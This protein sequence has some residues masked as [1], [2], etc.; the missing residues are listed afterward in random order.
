MGARLLHQ[1]NVGA[2]APAQPIAQPGDQFEPT[3]PPPTATM[4]WMEVEARGRSNSGRLYIVVT[5]MA[6]VPVRA[7]GR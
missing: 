6:T 3:G 2:A 5:V 4:R 1:R 7:R